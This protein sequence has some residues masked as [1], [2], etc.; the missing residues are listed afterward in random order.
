MVS[1]PEESVGRAV[2]EVAPGEVEPEDPGEVPKSQMTV[3]DAR[4]TAKKAR[5]QGACGRALI[6]Q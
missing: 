2:S 4:D 1:G 3:P 5:R 6:G